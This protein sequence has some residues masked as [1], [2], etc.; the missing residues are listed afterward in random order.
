MVDLSASRVTIF[1]MIKSILLSILAWTLQVDAATLDACFIRAIHWVE[2]SERLGPI[3]GDSGA[4]LGPL[5]IH[6]AYWLDATTYDKT[7]KGN[8][9]DCARL[10]YSIKIMT[11]Y[12]NKYSKQDIISS[13]YMV[14]AR[15]H[16]GGPMGHK[17]KNTL[18]YAEKVKV[19][20]N[21]IKK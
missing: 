5:Q 19:A 10:D 7:I 13:N 4:A 21:Q 2:T 8:Y 6:K 20:L 9:S 16:N 3:L 1:P 15:K 12:L 18:K 17:N 11:A 14:L